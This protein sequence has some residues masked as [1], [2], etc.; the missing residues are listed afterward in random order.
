M[1]RLIKIVEKI[2]SQKIL[3]IFALRL[4]PSSYSFLLL[5][6]TMTK[7][8]VVWLCVLELHIPRAFR[9]SINIEWKKCEKPY[10]RSGKSEEALVQASNFP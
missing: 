1:D 9:L 4:T 3:L 6:S 7:S 2:Y 10:S 8:Y 5:F